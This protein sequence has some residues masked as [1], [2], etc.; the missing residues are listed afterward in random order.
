MRE[1]CDAP[2][3]AL[4][5]FF[6]GPQAE[7]AAW[8]S[9]ALLEILERWYG[10]RRQKYPNDGAAISVADQ[11]TPEFQARKKHFLDLVDE[12]CHRFEAEVPK[13]SPRYIGHMFSEISLPALFGHIVATLHNPNNISGEA[14]R[15]G[16]QIENEAIDELMRMCGFNTELGTGH[17]TSGGTI[18]N[19]EAAIRARLRFATWISTACRSAD[20]NES[21]FSAAHAG[22][23]R[24]DE[25]QINQ[26]LDADDYDLYRNSSFQVGWNISERLGHFAE[27]VILVPEHR[28]YS[29][30]KIAIQLGFGRKNLIPIA[31]GHRGTLSTDDLNEKIKDCV[32]R[33]VPIAMV[34]SVLGTTEL[35]A[36]DP[37]ADVQDLL[38]EY[39]EKGVHIWHHIDAAYGGF[40]CSLKESRDE[41]I[42]ADKK[43]QLAAVCQANSLTI[44]P[45]KLG[46]VP[47]SSGAVLIA[48][49]REYVV[50]WQDSPYIDF[51]PEDRGHYTLEGSRSATGAVA[52]WLTARSIG[53]NSE[54]YGRILARTIR[55]REELAETLTKTVPGIQIL[56][57]D[58]N[59]LCF[60]VGTNQERLSNVNLRTNRIYE[61]FSTRHPSDFFV[62]KTEMSLKSYRKLMENS[63]SDWQLHIDRENLGLIRVCLMNPFFSSRQPKI[64]FPQAFATALNDFLQGHYDESQIPSN[65]L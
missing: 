45:H 9:A 31:L 23:S 57:A 12:I 8:V 25:M 63:F 47:Y 28:H 50:P 37:I 55:A 41:H 20:W 11:N 32:Q 54:G 36:F 62:S 26:K 38:N 27:P 21:F 65:R 3:I 39:R 42:G 49:R 35:G 14:S 33:Q 53:L 10:W 16:M 6:L 22:W 58:S 64:Y 52:T 34:V 51:S 29:W 59:I 56:P 40:F 43:R 13:F 46:Y 18:A 60:C 17:F 7:N 24:H 44:D 5:S 1:P 4:K 30:E 15:V 61:H 48:N 19:F 2:D